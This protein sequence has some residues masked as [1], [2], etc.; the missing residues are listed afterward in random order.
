MFY[1]PLDAEKKEI[2]LLHL[3]PGLPQS[4]VS[5]KLTT[6]SLTGPTLP[7]YEA[8][9][10]AWGV[11]SEFGEIVCNG[12]IIKVPASAERALRGLRREDKCRV[13][14]IDAVCINQSNRTEREQQVAMMDVVYKSA[15]RA[16]VYLSDIDGIT[17]IL[18][19][20][21]A[22]L[23]E[24]HK[25][26]DGLKRLKDVVYDLSG[27]QH[28]IEDP[29]HAVNLNSIVRLYNNS[30][31]SRLWVVQEVAL[32]RESIC[33]CGRYEIPW[34]DIARTSVWL[35]YKI[36]QDHGTSR[37]HCA[38]IDNAT[39]MWQYSERTYGL[40]G[41]GQPRG[42]SLANL[43]ANSRH[44]DTSDPRD[45]V[46]GLIA[47]TNWSMNGKNLPAEI[48]PNYRKSP[49]ETYRDATR[50]AIKEKED[51]YILR[52]VFAPTDD[53][54]E[55]TSTFPSWVPRWHKRAAP[56]HAR[57]LSKIF[58]AGRSRQMVIGSCQGPN[59]LQLVGSVFDAVR[60]VSD[61]VQEKALELSSLEDSFA[62]F[63][64]AAVPY[65]RYRTRS[66]LR[67]AVRMT[68]CSGTINK[69]L[70]NEKTLA[71]IFLRRISK[72]KE[73]KRV[74]PE[75]HDSCRQACLNRRFFVTTR[76]YL[77]LGPQTMQ[78]NDVV[79]VLFGGR[80]P[81]ILRPWMGSYRF[82]GECYVHGIMAGEGIECG[83]QD[84]KG[85]LI[86]IR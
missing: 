32:A 13:L 65:S 40:Y 84:E 35:Q 24:M 52:Y 58:R 70:A 3:T 56:Y 77:G 11:A 2:R 33:V 61:I 47:L 53:S 18:D 44:F 80:T 8:I 78:V 66:S 4:E 6:V 36:P 69:H 14:W 55:E 74:K 22:I 51:L 7:D 83:D 5:C 67:K 9:S 63:T 73:I 48:R 23:N 68:M 50:L 20:M 26:T 60:Q 10:Y 45:K 12:K 15:R 79:V 39:I 41:P 25:A 46:Y 31:F 82:I 17:E 49:A 57:P 72:G 59:C 62:L 43:L 34:M 29:L 71:D 64:N 81:F 86:D 28:T 85:F 76:G 19:S 75:Y 30:W 1:R 27:L 42:F 21:Q 38:G 37:L 54:T 16:V